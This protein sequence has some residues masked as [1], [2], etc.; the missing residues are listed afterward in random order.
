MNIQAPFGF[1][2]GCHAEAKY[3]VKATLA[4][5]RHYCP[6]VPICLIADGDYDASDLEED[7]G[8]IIMRVSDLPSKEMRE[9]VSGSYHVQQAAMW[10]GPFEFYVWIDCDA[11]V[12]GD[13]ISQVRTDLDFQIFWSEIS[14]PADAKE[15]PSW[16]PHYFFDPE[17]LSKFDPDFEWRGLPYFCTGVYACRRNLIS[18]ERWLEVESWKEEDPDL[19]GW[20]NMGTAVYHIHSLAQQGKIKTDMVDLQHIWAHHGKK[21]LIEDCAGAGWN[22]PEKIARPRV[23]HFCGIKPNIFNSKSYCKPFTIARLEHYRR[24][25]GKLGAWLIVLS[26]DALI[27]VKKL[28]GRVLRSLRK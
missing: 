25:H 8:V 14:I 11:V 18:F 12:W 23:A 9:F 22:F 24:H 6:E 15:V 16:L 7:Y 1:I 3:M 27:T 10:E 17:K 19:F 21:E 5:M 4:S 2:T 28:W 13:F 20:G 26:E